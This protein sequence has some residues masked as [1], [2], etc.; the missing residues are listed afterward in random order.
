[1][2]PGPFTQVNVKRSGI[3]STLLR[4]HEMTAL[5]MPVAHPIV[6][7]M[8]PRSP[9]ILLRSR[10]ANSIDDAT[11]AE[12]VATGCQPGP[13]LIAAT[14]VGLSDVGLA[15]VFPTAPE[16]FAFTWVNRRSW[17]FARQRPT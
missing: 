4:F 3:G 1:M 10:S 6:D 7:A 14:R 12:A 9:S 5:S 2:C 11:R 16:R 8:L 15:G 17:L 13:S